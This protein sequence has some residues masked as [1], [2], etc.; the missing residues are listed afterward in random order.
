MNPERPWPQL[1]ELAAVTAQAGFTLRERLT[2]YPQ[3]LRRQWLDPSV[4]PYVDALADAATGLARE[5][6]IPQGRP[7]RELTAASAGGAVPRAYAERMSHGVTGTELPPPSRS[8]TGWRAAAADPAGLPDDG[9]AA[10]LGA[11]GPELDEL[12]RLADELRRQAV[13]DELTYVVN[14]NLDPPAVAGADPGQPG[15]AGRPGNR[16]ADPRGDRDLP[17]GGAARRLRGRLPRPDRRGPG[18]RTGPAPARVPPAGTA[19]RGRPPR[20]AAGGVPGRRPAGRARLGAG[21]RRPHPRRRRADPDAGRAGPPG[22]PLDRGRRGRPPGRADLHLHRG[23]RACRDAGAAGRAPAAAGRHPGPY[24][25]VHRVHRHA[26]R[27]RRGRGH[28]PRPG[29]R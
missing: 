27:A 1:D 11:D 5:D 24:R 15:T 7:Y 4:A 10:L 12:A 13:G 18:G 17:A 25:R 16:G 14:R 20:A 2:V 8:G 21:H 19:R 28:R 9:Y 29:R 23:L 6:A 3:Y 26:V 22:G